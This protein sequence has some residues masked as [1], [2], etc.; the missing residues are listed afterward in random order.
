MRVAPVGSLRKTRS[1]FQAFAEAANPSRSGTQRERSEQEHEQ[2]QEQESSYKGIIQAVA[3]I[4]E[5]GAFGG[6]KD[7]FPDGNGVE[8]PV[9]PGEAFLVSSEIEC[10]GSVENA[11]G[12]R[13]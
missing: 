6:G 1:A 10:R 3:G 5:L 7:A 4:V 8:T 9:E 11:A 12:M 13:D 2:D